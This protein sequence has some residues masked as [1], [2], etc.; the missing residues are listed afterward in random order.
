MYYWVL[1]NF[2]VLLNVTYPHGFPPPAV[3]RWEIAHITYVIKYWLE[4]RLVVR[5]VDQHTWNIYRAFSLDV[6]YSWATLAAFYSL[7][8]FCPC[9]QLH[10][11]YFPLGTLSS[12]LLSHLHMLAKGIPCPCLTFLFLSTSVTVRITLTNIMGVTLIYTKNLKCLRMAAPSGSIG[13]VR[14]R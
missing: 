3:N 7:L 9:I 14:Y 8:H 10:P 6:S 1:I 2:T 5:L 11:H 4:N 12:L 13:H